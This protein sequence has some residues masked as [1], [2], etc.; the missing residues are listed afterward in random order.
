M[1]ESGSTIG[2][3]DIEVDRRG[4]AVYGDYTG[5]PINEAA[6]MRRETYDAS[7]FALPEWQCRPHGV[8]FARRPA[9]AQG[10]T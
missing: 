7:V 1:P 2:H 5:L 6:R 10:L 3:E 8:D 9:A 4:G